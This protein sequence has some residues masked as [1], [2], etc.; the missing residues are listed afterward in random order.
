[1]PV[2]GVLV[3]RLDAPIYYA[4]AL[5]VGAAIETMVKAEETPPRAVVLDT[6][7]QD[8]LD[9][10]SAEMLEKLVGKLRRAGVDVAAA[11]VHAPVLDF[12]R[13]TGLLE[14]LGPEH[15]FP[16]VDAAVDTLAG[17]AGPS[18]PAT[19]VGSGPR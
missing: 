2:P 15:V 5:T 10:T 7:V 16:T 12:A 8:S 14:R 17:R 13:T 18:P 19:S 1:V 9:I 11:E 4:N 6:S 3:V